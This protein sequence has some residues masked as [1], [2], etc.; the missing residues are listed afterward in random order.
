[1]S[2]GLARVIRYKPDDEKRSSKY[3]DLLAA[4]LRAEKKATGLHS[5]KEPVTMKIAEISNVSA[6]SIL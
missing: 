6:Y 4:E 1:M 2:Q 5:T 3:D